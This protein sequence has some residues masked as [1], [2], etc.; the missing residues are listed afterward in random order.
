[1][2]AEQT[3]FVTITLIFAWQQNAKKHNCLPP[4]SFLLPLAW[5]YAFRMD[6]IIRKAAFSRCR[7]YRYAL[8]REWDTSKPQVL[9][10]GL[11]PATADAEKDD[12][13][14]RRCMVYARSWGYGSMVVANLFAFRTT[15]PVELKKASDPVGTN[16][17]RWLRKLAKSAEMTV[18]VWGNDGSFLNRAEEI[19]KTLDNLYCFKITAQGQPHHTRGL[20]NG[21]QPQPF[22]GGKQ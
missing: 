7:S 12:N 8:W 16:N 3:K 9:F 5:C 22:S 17:D 11:N 4:S 1:M 14:M 21:L 19:G 10:I 13:T 6:N 20:P 15:W 18:A 2:L